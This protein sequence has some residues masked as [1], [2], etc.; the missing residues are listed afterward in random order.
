[1]RAGSSFSLIDEMLEAPEILRRFDPERVAD[2][3]KAIA[4]QKALFFTGEGS[5]RIFPAKNAISLA[6]RRGM[7]WH[8]ATEGARQAAGYKL[9]DFFVVGISNSGRTRELISLFEM[10]KEQHVPRHGITAGAG[11][12]LTEVADDCRVLSCGTEKA[13]AATKSV[14]EQALLCQALL[15]GGEWK[16]QA[17]AADAGAA[18]LAQDVPTAV[19]A[20]LQSAPV[21]YY[22]GR[23]D[24]VAE[25]LAL[26]SMEIVRRKSL[27]LEGTYALHGIEEVMRGGEALVLVEP[28]REEI[29]KYRT[30]LAQGA[31]LNVVAIASFDTPFPTLKIP[32]V[33]GFDAYLQL[34]AG[35]NIL[36][37]TGL[38]LG[39]NLDKPERARKVGN[40]I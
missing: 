15:A 21:I 4:E 31:G 28:F 6:L 32:A 10:L 9:G 35:W 30:V 14:I 26:K 8:T 27:Y 40:E 38:A 37:A 23:N 24:G 12:R 36:A 20:A 29:E 25:E 39:I 18:I 1:M 22:A 3:A 34:M 7:P 5:S 17:S 2:W 11:S 19:V 33:E 16:D 13:V